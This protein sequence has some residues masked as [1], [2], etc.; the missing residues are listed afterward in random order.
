MRVD[1]GAKVRTS[2]GEAAGRVHRVVINPY[3]SE[4]SQFVITTAGWHAHDVL[5]PRERLETSTQDGD[6]VILGLTGD[7]LKA[8]P[9]YTP[10]DYRGPAG[11]WVPPAES[12]Y[13]A[14]AWLF[15]ASYDLR[16]ELAEQDILPE[17]D[18]EHWPD[19]HKGAVVRD[20]DG[21]EVGRVDQVVL[22]NDT[23]RLQGFVIRAGGAI[24]TFLGGG[25]RL[26][27]AVS[28]VAAVG[29]DLV[30]LRLT[31]QQLAGSSVEPGYP[32]G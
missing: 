17:K 24:R 5:I 12:A 20:P 32:Q 19:I 31:R 13:P 25:D 7:E 6:E 9:K 16:K 14:S 21:H 23:G 2:D 28:D 1:L 22:D 26:T 30:V 29:T 10:E 4:V 27:V 15:P 18:P 8:L 3:T 11:G